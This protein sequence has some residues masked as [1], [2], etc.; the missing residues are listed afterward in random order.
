V[1][2]GTAAAGQAV[3][4]V[5][6]PPTTTNPTQ[7]CA[8]MI[9]PRRHPLLEETVAHFTSKLPGWSVRLYHSS[10]NEREARLLKTSFPQ[11][12]LFQVGGY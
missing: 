7:G 1:R 2:R 4:A 6:P 8:V 3:V 10:A 11:L 12:E 5:V 9:E